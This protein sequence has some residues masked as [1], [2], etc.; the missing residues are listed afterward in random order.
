[1]AASRMGEGVNRNSKRC[2]VRGTPLAE[3]VEYMRPAFKKSG[4][5][6]MLVSF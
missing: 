6:V 3:A 1:M 5:E 2:R 4:I